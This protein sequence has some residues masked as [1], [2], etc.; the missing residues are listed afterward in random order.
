MLYEQVVE[1][2]GRVIPKRHDCEASK[3]GWKV[4]KSNTGE[5]MLE[6]EPLDEEDLKR[7]LQALYDGG[8]RSIAVALMHSY[9]YHQHEAR[10]EAIATEM[11]FTHVS[12][13]SKVMP[14][15]RIVPRGFTTSV[16]TYL[17]PA[18][19]RYLEG[20]SAGFAKNLNG[21]NVQFMQSDGG[22]TP[23]EFFN[24]SRAIL[25]GPAGG[26]VGYAAT[27]FAKETDQ[28]V[29]GFD[30]GGTST[31]VSR[32]DGSYQHV[33]ETTT[34]GVTIQAPQLDISTVA[35][36]G[37]SILSFRAG[38]F[39]AGPDS[40][41]A[42]PGPVCYRKGG[43]LTIT[44][45]N[46]VLGRLLPSYFPKIFGPK[47][48]ESLDKESA[49]KAFEKMAKEVNSF[50]GTNLSVEEVA[51]GFIAVANESMCRPIR[52]LTQ[53][54]G[55]DTRDH[56]LACFG[57]AGGQHA[58]AIARSLGMKTVFIHK[59]AGILSAYGMALA[60][61]C[62]EEQMPS[63]LEFHPSNFSSLNSSLES[64]SVKCIEALHNQGFENHLIRTEK[65]LHMRYQGTDCALM[66]SASSLE[67]FINSFL[68][69]Y[70]KEFGFTMPNRT[71]LI[72]DIRVRGVGS[73]QFGNEPS[74]PKAESSVPK[75]A[76]TVDVFF[77]GSYERT[78]V[79]RM[80]DLT[81]GHIL[82]GPCIIMD[83][84]ST[85][86][87]EPNCSCVV[88]REG[89]LRIEVGHEN[90]E[91]I[92]TELDTIQLSV[93]SHRFMSIAGELSHSL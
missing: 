23:M 62:H 39:A 20:F 31:D 45:A 82:Q 21:V 29:I 68:Q 69:Q 36:G 9:V 13:S 35:A 51:Q 28:A 34:A 91:N 10:V 86:L 81:Y 18:I 22:L 61:V 37:G 80:E 72:D 67:G 76:E 7:S 83:K 1:V 47:E 84:L 93:F 77:D 88:S 15:M 8:I 73:T 59:Y 41:S 57:G 79:Y 25:S 27:T 19:K 85:I 44:D 64:L 38:L 53:G 40:A 12:L 6:V 92:S 52:N 43:P 30:M 66:C 89:N 14:M 58:C 90:K 74:L 78:N 32:F 56:V 70:K 26:V 63:A 87:V 24:G 42:H 48:N 33:F 11:G 60:D 65:F 71:V 54:K 17:T 55:Y 3:D 75:P 2:K 50:M 49:L 16:D 4:V 5:D 46:L